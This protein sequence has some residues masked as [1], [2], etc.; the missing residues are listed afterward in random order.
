[1]QSKEMRRRRILFVFNEYDTTE[2]PRAPAVRMCCDA[3]GTAG[4]EPAGSRRG[5]C[6]SKRGSC[7]LHLP[8]PQSR[9]VGGSDDDAF[10]LFLQKQNL[11]QGSGDGERASRI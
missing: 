2:G 4:A 3:R 9:G 1:M 11:K 6:T 7:T 5:C 8:R 10:Y